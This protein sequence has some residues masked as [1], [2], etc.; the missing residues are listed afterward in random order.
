V[1]WEKI[2][3]VRATFIM[4]SSIEPEVWVNKC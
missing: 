4:M 3:D 1:V 2:F